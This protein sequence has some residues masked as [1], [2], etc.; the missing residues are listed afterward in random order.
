MGEKLGHTRSRAREVGCGQRPPPPFHLGQLPKMALAFLMV[1]S[2]R[3]I[4][5]PTLLSPA[6][7][8]HE[9]LSMPK[10]CP[11]TS[12]HIDN[13]LVVVFFLRNC[14]PVVSPLRSSLNIIVSLLRHRIPSYHI[15]PHHRIASPSPHRFR[16]H[17][18]HVRC[19]GLIGRGV[20]D[21]HRLSIADAVFEMHR[22]SPPPA[23]RGCARSA[24]LG[25][26]RESRPDVRQSCGLN[27]VLRFWGHT[28]PKATVFPDPKDGREGEH[29]LGIGAG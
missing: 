12:H 26:N 17:R 29:E 28:R 24:R 23:A 1:C 14:R 13:V 15:A 10:G 9:G 20:R 6:S 8:L 19:H 2:G 5:H 21:A 18:P 3:L 22:R 16:S 27:P 4:V 11:P 25:A 7:S